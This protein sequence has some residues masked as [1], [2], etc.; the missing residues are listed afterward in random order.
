MEEIKYKVESPTQSLSAEVIFKVMNDPLVALAI[1]KTNS[2]YLH[3]QELKNKTWIPTCKHWRGLK[4]VW[5]SYDDK[6][7]FWTVLKKYRA[8]TSRLTNIRDADGSL[9]HMNIKPYEEFLHVVDKE[10]AGNFM[11]V[12]GFTEND[13][14]QFITRNIIEESIASSQLEGANTSREA[15][16]KMLLEKR[17]PRD[18]SEQMIVNNHE[19]MKAIEDTFKDEELSL[20]LLLELHKMITKN[21]LPQTQQGV[22]RETFD[23]KGNPLVIKPWDDRIIAYEAPS[24][25]FVEQELP[26]L[27][28][29]A[30]DKVNDSFIHP[31]I[32]AI[33]LHFWVGLLHPFED[34]NGRLARVLFYWYVLRKEYWAF[35]YLSLSEKILKSSKQ[36]AMAYIYSEQEDNDLNYFIDYNIQK[37]QLARRDFQEY[38]TKKISE[39]R[40]VAHMVLHEHGLNERQIKLIQY[41]NK[42]HEYTTLKQYQSVNNIGKVTA[43]TDLRRLVEKNMLK[44]LKRGRNTFYYVT[45][46]EIVK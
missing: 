30:N 2:P 44:K 35:A 5:T 17:L 12:M 8:F 39:N 4:K 25:E 18:K 29:F 43:A 10:M 22:L 28:Q 32:K 23:D 21:T 15:A 1:E 37:L 41:L 13:K 36:Y 11:G 33:L 20:G 27:I 34:G 46:K 38:I 7:A 19:T 16:K 40:Q 24:R 3:W 26:K 14:K 45:K 31:V 6:K 9:Y 42:G